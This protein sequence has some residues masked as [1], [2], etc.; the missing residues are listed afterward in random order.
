MPNDL[1]LRAVS[2]ADAIRAAPRGPGAATV[3]DA[4]TAIATPATPNPRLRLDGSLGMV[5]L[6]FRGADGEVSNTIPSRRAIA[7]YRAA[8]I[9]DAPVP[10]G[11][12][13]RVSA[14]PEPAPATE[15]QPG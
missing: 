15:P 7:A 2:T 6:E 11:V 14:I 10:A 5:V 4:A 13:P 12:A 9:S 1:V 3:P 8:A